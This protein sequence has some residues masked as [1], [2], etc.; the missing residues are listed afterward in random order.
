[1]FWCDVLCVACAGEGLFGEECR[2]HHVLVW[3]HPP[4]VVLVLSALRNVGRTM[5][6][7]G[8]FRLVLVG[9]AVRLFSCIVT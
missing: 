5:F 7:C 1:M 6:W 9:V 3:R 8:V 2:L 4:Q